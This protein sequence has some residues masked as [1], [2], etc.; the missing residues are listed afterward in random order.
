MRVVTV[1]TV[2][3]V[4]TERTLVTL[5]VTVT[6]TGTLPGSRLRPRIEAEVSRGGSAMTVVTAVLL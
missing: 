1:V 4:V 5:L 3:M 2:M 6:T